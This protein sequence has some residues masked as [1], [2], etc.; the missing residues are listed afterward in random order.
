MAC[1]QNIVPNGQGLSVSEPDKFSSTF[2]PLSIYPL[3]T[4]Q[5]QF[6]VQSEIF[7]ERSSPVLW[8]VRGHAP[9]EIFEILVQNGAIWR[10]LRTKIHVFIFIASCLYLHSRRSA[11]DRRAA[12]WIYSPT[13]ECVWFTNRC[14]RAW[15]DR[16]MRESHA[17][18]VR[19][20]RSAIVQVQV[21]RRICSLTNNQLPF[22]STVWREIREIIHGVGGGGGGGEG[23]REGMSPLYF[24]RRMR[25]WGRKPTRQSRRYTLFIKL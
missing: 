8:G 23:E 3:Q 18:C 12:N 2:S 4:S 9:R 22:L 24:V 1:L 11:L 6:G 17:Q 10:I 20:V 15:H 14:V 21:E 19:L 13:V 25:E 16:W 7:G 5:G